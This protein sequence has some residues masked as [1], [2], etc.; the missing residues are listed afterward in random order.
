MCIVSSKA[1]L[2]LHSRA[3]R[4]EPALSLATL[5]LP[6]E[7]GAAITTAITTPVKGVL[8]NHPPATP[9][10]A[11]G[12]TWRYGTLTAATPHTANASR[13]SGPKGRSGSGPTLKGVALTVC[14]VRCPR[15]GR[16]LN[17]FV[18]LTPPGSSN[19]R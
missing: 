1:S 10:R 14:V 5:H 2:A 6:A 19:T 15:W 3:A 8:D 7:A 13:T 18:R 16:R 17:Y 11:Q 9:E 4:A 12:L